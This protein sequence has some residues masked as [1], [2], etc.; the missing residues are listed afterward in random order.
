MYIA[1]WVKLDKNYLN[2]EWL[3][4][5][6]DSWAWWLEHRSGNTDGSPIFWA[7][8]WFWENPWTKKWLPWNHCI[9]SHNVGCKLSKR[10]H[11]QILFSAEVS[12]LHALKKSIQVQFVFILLHF[13]MHIESS[14]GIKV[15]L[16]QGKMPRD[17]CADGKR[18]LEFRK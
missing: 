12:V 3:C 18:S 4:I 5:M 15:D 14:Y 7:R 6:S 16:Y 17:Q 2:C 13:Y 8:S 11:I 1:Q 9:L 10:W